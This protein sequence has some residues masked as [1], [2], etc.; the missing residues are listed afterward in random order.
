[1]PDPLAAIYEQNVASVWR[2]AR[3]RVPDH[4]DAEDVTSEVFARAARAWDRYDPSRGSV[5]AWL[6][7]I[8]HHVVADW[9]RG[10]APELPVAH[11]VDRADAGP[12]PEGVVEA[13][14]DAAGLHRALDAAGLTERE[15]EAVA[16]RFG[17]GL[18]SG[19][20][21]SVLGVSDAGARMLVYR[22]VGKLRAV[23]GE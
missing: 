5:A 17:A 10:R 21:G 22:A 1:V 8:A 2:Y 4:A 20:V 9:W 3:A 6:A 18:S 12:S 14:D 23:V 16:L 11:M 7:G 13:K 19:E 15:R